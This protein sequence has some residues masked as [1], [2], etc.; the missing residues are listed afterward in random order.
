MT[1]P[2]GE[3]FIQLPGGRCHFTPG[4]SYW[5][6]LKFLSTIHIGLA[7]L[8]PSDY[9]RCRSDVKFLEYASRGV[10]GVYSRLEPYHRT[11]IHGKT[12]LVYGNKEE[13]EQCLNALASDAGLRNH[14]RQEAYE[15]VARN[16]LLSQHIEERLRFYRE[17]LPDPARS[18]EVP[19]EALAVAER[20]GRYL[21]LRPQ[22]PEQRMMAAFEL[23]TTPQSAE[24]LSRLLDQYP[25]YLSALQLQGQVLNELRDYRRALHYLQR[26]LAVRPRSARTLCQIGRA[27]L[28]LGDAER[29]CQTLIAG[30]ELNPLY[31][32]GWM[33]LLG[34]LVRSN[35]PDGARWA[36]RACVLHPYSYP[37]ALLACAFQ[38]ESVAV[39]EVHGVLDSYAPTFTAEEMP[40]AAR[41]FS[42]SL[43]VFAQ[44][45]KGAPEMLALLR[46]ACEVFPMSARM[47]DVYGHALRAAGRYKEANEEHIRARRLQLATVGYQME[48]PKEDWT[49]HL[50][51]FAE[52]VER[53]TKDSELR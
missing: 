53:W 3:H 30:L 46:R 1:N 24:A 10:V 37:L 44:A 45:R 12:G 20:E 5:E 11:V 52:N 47:A 9:N 34:A 4:G 36:R 2:V 51:Q 28:G 13:F 27:Q 31:Y 16:R 29:G 41:A 22:D 38:P 43:A 40:K 50:W 23:G 32:P 15:Y 17:L 21:Q 48:F 7:P 19:Q 49:I 8:L 26:A 18:S 14:I 33:I 25:D 6:Y 39:R 35:S 42:Q